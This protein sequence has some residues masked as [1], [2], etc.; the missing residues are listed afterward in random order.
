VNNRHALWVTWTLL[1]LIIILVV[2]RLFIDIK[3]QGLLDQTTKTYIE[4]VVTDKIKT[5]EIPKNGVD[6]LNGYTPVKGVDYFDGE[7]GKNGVDG[8][9]GKDGRNPELRCDILNNRWLVRYNPAE[10]WQMPDGEAVACTVSV[11]DI[12]EALGEL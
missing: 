3:R 6:G 2:V 8:K 5:I 9:D 7:K 12:L 1:V 11:S 10:N 4:K